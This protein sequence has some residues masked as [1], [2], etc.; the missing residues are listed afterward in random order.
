MAIILGTKQVLDLEE[1]KKIGIGIS[2]PIQR[3]NDGFFNQTFNTSDAIKTN[4]KNLLL[5]RKGERIMQ[6]NFGTNLWNI[7]F[8]NDTD[9]T[10]VADKIEKTIEMAIKFWLPF[11]SIEQIEINKDTPTN[12]DKHIYNVSILFR[13]NGL[14]DLDNVTFKISN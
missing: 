3:G 1:S 14:Q 5:T 9:D 13:A 8:E 12:R 2:L 7:L 11:I 4:I 6:P 10:P